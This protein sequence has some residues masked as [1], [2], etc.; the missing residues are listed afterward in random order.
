MFVLQQ[1][2]QRDGPVVSR[3]VV[4][5]VGGRWQLE[6]GGTAYLRLMK[7]GNESMKIHFS[8]RDSLFGTRDYRKTV[9]T[10]RFC[11]HELKKMKNFIKIKNY[12][13]I[14]LVTIAKYF[15]L[16]QYGLVAHFSN[17]IKID[18]LLS[19]NTPPRTT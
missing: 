17:T 16:V 15:R 2:G 1:P 18:P 8:T 3:A 5:L 7:S 14:S 9:V 11:S 13:E 10:S 4:A 12:L 19:P 6:E